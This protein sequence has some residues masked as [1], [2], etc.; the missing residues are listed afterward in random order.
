MIENFFVFLYPV[1]VFMTLI[2]YVPQVISII[3][4]PE[5]SEGISLSTWY[6]WSFSS[7]LATGYTWLHVGDLFLIISSATNLFFCTLISILLLLCRHKAHLM[8]RAQTT[9]VEVEPYN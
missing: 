5:K 7:F 9:L 6:L 8:A 3:R 2:G 1:V 4:N